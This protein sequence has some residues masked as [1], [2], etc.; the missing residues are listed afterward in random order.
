MERKTLNQ[1]LTNRSLSCTAL[2]ALLLSALVFA[3][4]NDERT[5]TVTATAFNSTPAQTDDRPL[6]TAC[7]DWLKPNSRI[8]AVS[9]DL[10]KLGLQCGTKVNIEGL[11]GYWTVADVTAARH[12]QLIDIYMGGDIKR[13]R[14]WGR[15]EVEISWNND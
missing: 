7:G 15:Q 14:K 8:I 11:E 10:K 13:A 6:E 12:Q 9:R 1:L 5:L 4:N 2:G 3:G